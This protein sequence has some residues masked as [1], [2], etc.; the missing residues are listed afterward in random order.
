MKRIWPV[1]INRKGKIFV[2]FLLSY[3]LI[4]L[5]PLIIGM[6]TYYQTVSV[7]RDD[8]AQLNLAILEQSE[9]IINKSLLEI[10]DI[11]SLLSID[12]HLLALVLNAEA[13][14]PTN[15]IYEFSLQRNEL[16]KLSTNKFFSDLFIYLEKSEAILSKD[17]IERIQYHPLQIGDLSF[18]QWL[19]Q[20]ISD[21]QLNRYHYLEN[22]RN[23]GNIG[24]YLTY[25]SALPS[26]YGGRIDGALVILIDEQSIIRLFDRLLVHEGSFA[27]I[28]DEHNSIVASAAANGTEVQPLEISNEQQ[29]NYH[30]LDIDG[31]N[32]LITYT[33]SLQNGWTYVA[34][35]P[36]EIV[37]SKADYIKRLTW[38]IALIALA[39]GCLIALLFAYRNSKPIAEV[40]ESIKDFAA[41]DPGRK[42]NE[43]DL[44]KHT[45][46][47]IIRSNKSLHIKMTQQLPMLQSAFLER[48]L[49]NNEQELR[50]HLKQAQMLIKEENM[51]VSITRIYNMD[52][53]GERE[54]MEDKERVKSFL[55]DRLPDGCFVHDLKMEKLA[56]LFSFEGASDEQEHMNSLVNQLGQYQDELVR[57]Y[58][59]MTSIGVGR[60]YKGYF[61]V[62]R[63]YNEASLALDY[64]DPETPQQMIR[65]DMLNG[66]ANQ[67]YYPLDLELRVMNTVRT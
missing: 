50:A 38:T 11:V 32:M 10:R 43:M 17:Y 8:A 24:N 39:L 34:G 5:I 44:L 13:S 56:I 1:N 47:Q 28:V 57:N 21:G 41:G 31:T 29:K 18:E 40:L 65:Y 63:S 23:G 48:L 2:K 53:S 14:W 59:I 16:N 7:V 51:L 54:L 49:K 58:G 36:A 15:T 33:R 45:V 3:F 42:S 25:I 61:N 46:N 27:Y 35:L 12:S 19:N 26:G 67:Y 64:Q 60:V 52:L 20:V 22:V 6:N 9:E 37:L 62:W 30:F 55:K 4:L 66:D